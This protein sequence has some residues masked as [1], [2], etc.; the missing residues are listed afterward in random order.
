MPERVAPEREA[1]GS[2]RW[3][4]ARPRPSPTS[5]TAPPSP[6]AG[7][8]CRQPDRADR[9]AARAGDDRSVHRE[10]Q[11]RRRRLGARRPAERPAHPQDDRVVRGREQG[12]RAAVPLGRARA[13]AH[14]AGHARRE[15]PRRRR[16]HRRLLHADGRGHAGRRGRA[17]RG[18]TTATA[19]SPSRRRPRTCARSAVG[20]D[21]ARV[22]AGGG[23]HHRLRAGARPARATGTATSCSTSRPAT[24]TRSR[25]WRGA[26][27]SPRSRSSSSRASSTPTPCTCPASTC[28]ASCEVGTDIEKRIERRTVTAPPSDTKGPE[29]WR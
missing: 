1:A 20:D 26:S 19:A 4:R 7:S 21:A 15:A 24:S 29:P 3:S 5:P 25:R 8:A 18:S 13:R 22:R 28:T 11:L 12:V 6:S 27:A 17:A 9:G 14:P 16:G 10:Q 23:D 2:T